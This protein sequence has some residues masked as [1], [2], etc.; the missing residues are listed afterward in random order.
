[1][2]DCDCDGAF[3]WEAWHDRVPGGKATLHVVGTCLCPTPEYKLLLRRRVHQGENP[4][5]LLLDLIETPPSA[6]QLDVVTE[7]LVVYREDTE[8]TY[9]TVTIMPD[10]PRGIPVRDVSK[11]G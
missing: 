5:D 7:E 2:A 8:L 9:E 10:G 11:T 1:V 3:A 6:P 4:K